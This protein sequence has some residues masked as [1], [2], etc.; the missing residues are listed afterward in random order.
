[1]QYAP[2]WA[3]IFTLENIIFGIDVILILVLIIVWIKR[4]KN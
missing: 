2:T 1:L 3:K 4:F